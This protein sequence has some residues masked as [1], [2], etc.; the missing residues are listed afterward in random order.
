MIKVSHEVPISL[1]EKSRSFN[2]YDYALVHLF[3][4][5]PEYYAF[6]EE[7]LKMGREV[8]LD[9]SIFELGTAFDTERFVYWIEKLKPTYYIIPDALEDSRNTLINAKEFL[10]NHK[11]LPGTPIVVAQG[12]T[13]EDL[14]H[15]YKFLDKKYNFPFLALSFDYSFF[16]EIA[17]GMVLEVENKY[18][19][20][21]LGR[22]FVLEKMLR[23][24]VINTSKPH[25]LL[26][27]S[28]P[29]EGLGYQQK[30]YD[31]I[32]SV[33]SSNPIVHGIKGIRYKEFGLSNKESI[34]LADLIDHKVTDWELEDIH[35]NV[36]KYK[37]FWQS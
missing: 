11:D 28:L 8:I 25:H 26:G 12:E 9:N 16:H 6:F 4:E 1:L 27:N 29:Q 15:C 36:T 23:E 2:D 31:W 17:K 24:G 34:K 21:M 22:Q 13:Y 30:K 35:F 32:K 19:G 10:D 3:E 5:H 18:Q 14:V 20:M 33:D 37:K 7:S